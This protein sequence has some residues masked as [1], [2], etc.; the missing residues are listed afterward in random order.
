LAKE[1]ATSALK[2][3][4]LRKKEKKEEEEKDER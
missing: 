1:A 2:C 3:V 4:G